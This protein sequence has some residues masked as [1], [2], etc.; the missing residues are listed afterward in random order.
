MKKLLVIINLVAASLIFNGCGP[1]RYTVTEQPVA[2]V[3]VRPASPGPAYV[4]VDGDWRW[5]N[6]KYVYSNGYWAQPRSRRVYVTGT[7]VRSN[8]GY[9][10]KK[11]YWK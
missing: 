1:S 2:P 3:Y 4:W 7:W 8:N 10:W 9:Y 6:G 11:G 5:H